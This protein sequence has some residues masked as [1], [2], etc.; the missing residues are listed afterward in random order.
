MAGET[1]PTAELSEIFFSRTP[2]VIGTADSIKNLGESN[3]STLEGGAKLVSGVSGILGVPVGMAQLS[4][5]LI[6]STNG[7]EVSFAGSKVLKVNKLATLGGVVL[8]GIGGAAG[9]TL[10]FVELGEK[11][12]D[13]G[14]VSVGTTLGLTSGALAIVVGGAAVIA[15]PEILAGLALYEI[16]AMA[17]GVAAFLTNDDSYTVDTVINYWSD[18]F[19][20]PDAATKAAKIGSFA[21]DALYGGSGKDI[22]YG[23]GGNDILSGGNEKDILYGDAGDDVLM[24]TDG[25]GNDDG[26][27]DYLKGGA[28]YDTYISGNMD[29]INDTD[30]KGRVYFEGQKLTGGVLKSVSGLTRTYEGDGGIYKLS[31]NTLTFTKE[32][33]ILTIENFH[34]LPKD[35]EINLRDKGEITITIS[36]ASAM[37]AQE[38]MGFAVSLRS[39]IPLDEPITIY[40]S[41]GSVTIPVGST[42]GNVI[43]EW[44]NDQVRE[45]KDEVFKVTVSGT[46]YTGEMTVIHTDTAI[47]TIKDDDP[48]GQCP[49]PVKPCFPSIPLPT[50]VVHVSSPVIENTY[51]NQPYIIYQPES[52]SSSSSYTPHTSTPPQPK[53]ECVNSPASHSTAVGGGGGGTGPIILDLNRDGITSISLAASQALFDYDGNG[54]KE[55]TAWTQRTDALLVNDVNNDGIINNGNLL[56]EASKYTDTVGNKELAADIQLSTDAKDTKVDINDIPNF[57]VDPIT[58][59]LPQLRRSGL[60]YDSFIHYNI[61]PEFKAVAVANN[62]MQRKVA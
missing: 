28:G 49:Q 32:G 35:L 5:S 10:Y 11:G 30:G 17:V 51:T 55:N 6:M 25:Y 19:S 47:G 53:V 23:G 15:G 38:Q 12:G 44:A 43:Y 16:A 45:C 39:D 22:I 26:V 2:L 56:V 36:D 40:T 1:I 21:D 61:D 41:V 62:Q 14:Q 58:N 42:S 46:S 29:I 37:E 9:I 24:G 34:K 4:T 7:G 57:T 52:S 27:T 31:G 13:T 3:V 8:G 54:S 59:L 50:P 20:S 18:F 33:K 60:V 48:E